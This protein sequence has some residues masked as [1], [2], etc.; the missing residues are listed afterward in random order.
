[1]EH[2]DKNEI[3]CELRITVE[4]FKKELD[5]LIVDLGTDADYA[6]NLKEIGINPACFL[7]S[8]PEEIVTFEVHQKSGLAV[9]ATMLI[10]KFALPV[11]AKITLDLWSKIILPRLQQRLGKASVVP[12]P[13][14]QH[15]Q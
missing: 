5:K 8:K 10:L 15:T 11:G 2:M 13:K 1:M 4:E 14:S 7:G 12:T 9:A 3:E 6:E